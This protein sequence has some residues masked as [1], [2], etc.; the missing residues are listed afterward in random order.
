MPKI[1]KMNCNLSI[2][3]GNLAPIF[4]ERCQEGISENLKPG[5]ARIFRLF[6]TRDG[7][8]EQDLIGLQLSLDKE[9]L[10]YR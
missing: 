9:R 7:S 5:P 10:L 3:Q 8:L 4:E 2:N 1:S 6:P